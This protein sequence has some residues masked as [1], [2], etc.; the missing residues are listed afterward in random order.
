MFKYV[1]DISKISH[2]IISNFLLNKNVAIDATLGNGHDTDFLCKNFDRVYSFD[3]QKTACDNYLEKKNDNVKVINDSHHM[4]EEYIDENVD[5][6][7]YNLGFLPGGDKNITTKSSTSL[8][9]IKI[10]LSMLNSGGIMTICLYRGHTEG[11]EEENLIIPY[12][13]KMDKSKYGV[14]YHSFLNRNENAPILIV[15]EKK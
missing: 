11:K 8:E 10:G 4:L 5:C 13:K 14:M 7:M 1:G 9:S 6:I 2:Y 3:I 12:L 15:I